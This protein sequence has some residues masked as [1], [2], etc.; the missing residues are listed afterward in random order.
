MG[1]KSERGRIFQIRAKCQQSTHES[2]GCGDQ[3]PQRVVGI[4]SH[5]GLWGSGAT[6]GCGDQEAAT[7]TSSDAF[8]CSA[9]ERVAMHDG[10]RLFELRSRL[11]STLIS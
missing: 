11:M 10:P 6:E 7:L 1:T 9:V 3:E 4:K 5:R 2:E 8:S